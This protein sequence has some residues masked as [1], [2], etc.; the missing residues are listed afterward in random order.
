[1]IKDPKLQWKNVNNKDTFR[2]FLSF[3]A[4]YIEPV[5]MQNLANTRI[6]NKTK[7]LSI[8]RKINSYGRIKNSNSRKCR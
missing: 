7:T 8:K 5:E 1:M 2:A 3:S 4:C 6:E